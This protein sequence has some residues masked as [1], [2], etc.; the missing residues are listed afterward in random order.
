MPKV[1]IVMS[2]V[3]SE[4]SVEGVF[5]SRPQAEA[6]LSDCRDCRDSYGPDYWIESWT[7]GRPDDR[8]PRPYWTSRIDLATGVRTRD[9]FVGKANLLMAGPAE[10]HRD[11]TPLQ[12]AAAVS[13]VS[14]A[15][16]DERADALYAAW[17]A[18]HPDGAAQL[19]EA[20]TLLAAARKRRPI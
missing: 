17:L 11:F 16:A 19:L 15:H 9:G 13:F 14:Q 10:T 5:S 1:H 3:D 6:Y 7:L 12:E 20:R 8:V 4:Q 2:G 18:D